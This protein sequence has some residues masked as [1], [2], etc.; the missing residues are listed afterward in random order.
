MIKETRVLLK[1]LQC[2]PFLT[3]K[4][5]RAVEERQSI[6]YKE[7]NL[8]QRIFYKY[9]SL[10]YQ[11]A[12]NSFVEIVYECL[13]WL[14]LRTYLFLLLEFFYVFDVC[15]TSGGRR[16][17]DSFEVENLRVKQVLKNTWEVFSL[18][19]TFH[20]SLSSPGLISYDR[21]QII[22]TYFCKV[23]YVG[24]RKNNLLSMV[25]QSKILSSGIKLNV[26]EDHFS[27][28]INWWEPTSFNLSYGFPSTSFQSTLSDVPIRSGVTGSGLGKTTLEIL[29]THGDRSFLRSL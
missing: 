9:S 29:L 4:W 3:C 20:A 12:Q 28:K 18:I 27:K 13:S 22:Y 15:L 10:P 25:L 26:F 16:S 23:A 7:D 21:F 19:K 6:Q 1:Q 14:V 17:R 11:K 2:S 24:R 8:Q 5:W